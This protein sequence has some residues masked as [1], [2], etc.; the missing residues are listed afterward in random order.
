MDVII[1]DIRYCLSDLEKDCWARF[2]NGAVKGRDPFHLPAVAN[3]SDGDISL[4]TVVLRKALIGTYLALVGVLLV[5]RIPWV[6]R[7]VGHDRLVIWHRKLAPYS[8]YLIGT[9]VLF[10]VLG[11]AGLEQ[12]P[13]YKELW[14]MIVDYRWVVWGLLGS[15]TNGSGG[16]AGVLG[17]A[18]SGGNV[19]AS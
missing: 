5:A 9:H 2:V 19:G 16:A 15:G 1:N 17:G 8:L 10:V 18:G 14:R 7:G 13:L 4:R 11:I 3:F 12:I 6:E